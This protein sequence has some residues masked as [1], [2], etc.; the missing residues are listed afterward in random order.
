V[1]VVGTGVTQ[2]LVVVVVVDGTIVVV[3]VIGDKV[4]PETYVKKEYPL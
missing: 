3:V 4:K 2:G 1:L